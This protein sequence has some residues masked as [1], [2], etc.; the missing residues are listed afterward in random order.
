MIKTAIDAILKS[1]KYVMSWLLPLFGVDDFM[2]CVHIR[3]ELWGKP[4]AQK[5]GAVKEV[6]GS[7]PGQ[8]TINFSLYELTRIW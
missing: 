8:T 3:Q 7:N 2:G 4:V 1:T 6:W 5:I